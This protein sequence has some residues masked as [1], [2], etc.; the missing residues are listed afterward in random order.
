[1]D[2][3]KLS[4]VIPTGH[5]G[6][7]A[8]EPMSLADLPPNIL[9]ALIPGYSIISRYILAVVGI[10]ISLFVSA[11][12]IGLAAT[13]GGQYLYGKLSR[14]FRYAFLSSVYIDESDDLFDMI[15]DWIAA[16]HMKAS[17]RSVRAKTQRGAKESDEYKEG[18]MNM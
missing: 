1:M 17:R 14:G 6:A 18:K 12:V 9:D 5:S 3:R 13:K 15:M 10:D 11:V 16:T 2:F 4:K 8:T 7:N